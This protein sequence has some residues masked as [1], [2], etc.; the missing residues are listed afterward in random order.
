MKAWKQ[1]TAA[2]AIQPRELGRPL[3]FSSVSTKGA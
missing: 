2:K 3:G 1:K